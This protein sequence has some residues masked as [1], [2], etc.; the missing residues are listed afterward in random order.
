MKLIIEL[1][2]ETN[3]ISMGSDKPMQ[4]DDLMNILFTVQLESMRGFIRQV[5]ASN[6]ATQEALQ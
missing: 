1:N 2:E 4:I 5:E 6:Y 3:Q